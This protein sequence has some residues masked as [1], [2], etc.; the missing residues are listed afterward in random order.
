MTFTWTFA[1]I[2]VINNQ[3][4]VP[5]RLVHHKITTQQSEQV[6]CFKQV[7]SGGLFN[8]HIYIFYHQTK[9]IYGYES[10]VRPP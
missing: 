1:Y 4:G 10:T 5:A 9:S 6:K 3:S 8:T 2:H 7:V